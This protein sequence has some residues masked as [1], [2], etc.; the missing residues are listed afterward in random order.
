[1]EPNAEHER[2]FNNRRTHSVY[3]YRLRQVARRDY[4]LRDRALRRAVLDHGRG[5]A[6]NKSSLVLAIIVAGL[7]GARH[8]RVLLRNTPRSKSE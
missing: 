2:K 7:F 6:V 8:V 4:R 3:I 5:A 1:M